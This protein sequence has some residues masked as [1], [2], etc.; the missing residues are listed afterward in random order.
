MG[1]SMGLHRSRSILAPRRASRATPLAIA[2]ASVLYPAAATLAAQGS[3]NDTLEEVI[4]TATR[5][6]VNLQDVAQSVT[7]LPPNSSRSRP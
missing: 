1:N 5:R 4:V 7:A 6:E 2:I 3:G